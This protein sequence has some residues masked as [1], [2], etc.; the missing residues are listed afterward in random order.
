MAK[1]CR[2]SRG[3]V[4]PKPRISA[5]L[6]S[7][8]DARLA[9]KSQIQQH[10]TTLNT[11]DLQ[12]LQGFQLSLHF[13][14]V[15]RGSLNVLPLADE[16]LSLRCEGERLRSVIEG[17]TLWRNIGPRHHLEVSAMHG[18]DSLFAAQE[19]FAGQ[20]SALATDVDRVEG[21]LLPGGMH[22][23]FRAEGVETWPH[24]NVHADKAMHELFGTK[25]H[26][27]AN[28]QGL[29]LSI[30][31]ASEAE[32]EP[33]YAGLRFILPLLPVLSAASPIVEGARGPAL[34]CRVGARH[35]LLCSRSA[36]AQT[37]VQRHVPPAL[38][39]LAAFESLV[40]GPLNSALLAHGVGHALRASDVSASGLWVDAKAGVV[41]V[42]MLDGQECL[43]ANMAVCAAVL[44]LSRH[45]AFDSSV[46]SAELDVWPAPRLDEL[47]QATIVDGE[48]A[49]LRDAEYLQ[50]WGFPEGT[51]CRAEELLQFIWEERLAPT[52]EE[53]LAPAAETIVMQGPLGRRIV[54]AL[55]PRFDDE[56]LFHTYRDVAK[57]LDE[58]AMFQSE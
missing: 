23:W 46:P 57:C 20:L 48:S 27:W 15:G 52:F 1:Y 49:I 10:G 24:G 40:A 11:S 30:P 14:L 44:A 12:G 18:F 58:N 36:F 5:A 38:E 19:F 4:A 47:V 39:A 17:D 7:Q 13:A 45:V 16:V 56:A 6:V 50:I 33:L 8:G 42:R 54:N 25:R 55:P 35:D 37:S 51:R 21:R 34:Q 2:L 43:S 53:T 32:F 29:G 26:G 28:Q 3:F 9:L 22:P 41:E 31:F